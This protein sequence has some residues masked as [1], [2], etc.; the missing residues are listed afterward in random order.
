VKPRHEQA[1][2]PRT[3]RWKATAVA[4]VAAGLALAGCG[5]ERIIT[6]TVTRTVATPPPSQAGGPK[7][8]LTR[9]APG[10]GE[11]LVTGDTAPKTFGPYDFEPGTYTFQFEQFAPDSPGLDFSTEASPFAVSVNR[12][13]R[14][15][16]PDSQ[17]LVN[18]AER[19][20]DNIVNLSGKFYVDVTSA[21]HSY[22]V[23]FT[24]R[25]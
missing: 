6:Q 25:H 4:A 18:S 16:A 23:R 10:P 11:V 17:L 21:D 1:R 13:P 14:A 19:R 9:T 24:P 3:R 12:K 5:G 8:T 22:V 7:P 20:G 15:S 2:R